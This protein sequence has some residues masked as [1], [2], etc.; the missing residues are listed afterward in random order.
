[1]TKG[2][3]CVKHGK[4]LVKDSAKKILRV[5]RKCGDCW[6]NF[7]HGRNEMCEKHNADFEEWEA[8]KVEQLRN[9]C[10]ECGALR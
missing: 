6:D 8:V 5:V 4:E 9:N 7:R 10:E 3:I 2:E 1:M